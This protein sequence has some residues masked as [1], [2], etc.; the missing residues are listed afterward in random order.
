MLTQLEGNANAYLSLV[1][2]IVALVDKDQQQDAIDLL[3]SRLAPQ[4][5]ILNKA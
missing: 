1:G 3:N 4:G 2:Q 5:V